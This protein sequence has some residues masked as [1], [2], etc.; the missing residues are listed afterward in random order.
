MRA[1]EAGARREERLGSGW[2]LLKQQLVASDK[3]DF[4][5]LY[6]PHP[7]PDPAPRK[8]PGCADSPRSRGRRPWPSSAVLFQRATPVA[9][10]LRAL[11]ARVG[12]MQ[13]RAPTHPFP[14]AAPQSPHLL[15]SRREG[16]ITAPERLPQPH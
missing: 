15:K 3:A 16:L 6:P 5:I 4:G 7:P 14:A 1:A 10:H 13:P 2:P 9:R 11:S 8:F 12:L